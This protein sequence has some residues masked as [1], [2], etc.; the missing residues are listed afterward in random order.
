MASEQAAQ[1]VEEVITGTD[2]SE[3]SDAKGRERSQVQ[4]P[5]QDLSEAMAIAKGVHDLGVPAPRSAS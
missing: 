5:Y 1:E 4:F 2:E 3:Q